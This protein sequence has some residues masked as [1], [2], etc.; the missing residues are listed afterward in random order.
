MACCSAR[1]I[2]LKKVN[3]RKA[4]K[5]ANK[6][7][8]GKKIAGKIVAPKKVAAKKVPA[9]KTPPCKMCGKVK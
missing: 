3:T 6:G 8:G 2:R 9:K 4:V 5:A 7:S 1:S